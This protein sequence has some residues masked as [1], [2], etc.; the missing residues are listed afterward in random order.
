M[1]QETAKKKVQEGEETENMSMIN[2]RYG[3]LYIIVKLLYII[4]I[5]YVGYGSYKLYINH[6]TIKQF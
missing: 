2:G 4:A 6:R 1:S 5:I 3:P